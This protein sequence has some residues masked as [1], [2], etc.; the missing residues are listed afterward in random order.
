MSDDPG[1]GLI[2]IPDITVMSLSRAVR[3]LEVLGLAWEVERADGEV[4]TVSGASVVMSQSPVPGLRVP[5][6]TAVRIHVTD[7]NA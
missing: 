4:G 3:L 5:L 2:H 1:M 6:G 7:W